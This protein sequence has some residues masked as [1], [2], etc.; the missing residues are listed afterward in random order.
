MPN[1][2]CSKAGLQ[3]GDIVLKINDESMTGKSFNQ[4]VDIFSRE[5]IEDPR[6]PDEEVLLLDVVA[7][8]QYFPD[9]HET[10]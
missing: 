3:R 5:T 4:I 1:S 7:K 9:F 2:P 6:D 10:R 8:L